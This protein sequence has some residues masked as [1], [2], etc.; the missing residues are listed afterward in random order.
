MSFGQL[1]PGT[2]SSWTY[3]V[4]LVNVKALL[5]QTFFLIWH[6]QTSWVFLRL[7]PE[8]TKK[9]KHRKYK[10]KGLDNL[11]TPSSF[12]FFFR[13]LFYCCYP[14]F[15]TFGTSQAFLLLV[16]QL[17]VLFSKNSLANLLNNLKVSFFSNTR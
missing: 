1:K 9:E 4:S 13:Y 14:F 10:N 15:K 7:Y 6:P 12:F 3:S 8:S 5:A 2:S 16:L 17:F 11:K